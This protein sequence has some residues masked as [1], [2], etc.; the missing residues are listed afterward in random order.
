[1]KENVPLKVNEQLTPNIIFGSQALFLQTTLNGTKFILRKQNKKTEQPTV[2]NTNINTGIL[3]LLI[4]SLL[5]L[6][7]TPF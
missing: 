3:T 1:M 7:N 5:I 6:S 2:K 4:T